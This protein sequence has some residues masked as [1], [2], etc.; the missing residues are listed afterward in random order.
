MANVELQV[1]NNL[2]K[3]V[4]KAQVADFVF[5]ETAP[6]SL[7]HQVVRW[8]RASWR[9]GTHKTKTRAEVTGGGRKPWKQKGSGRARQGSIRAVQW[10]GGGIA[11]GPNPRNYS[12]KQNRKERRIA[13]KSALSYKALDN[14]ITVIE[15]LDFATPKTKEMKTLLENLKLSDKKVLFVTNEL[16]ENFILAGRNLQNI[17]MMETPDVNVLDLVNADMVVITEAALKELEE[18]LG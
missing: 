17:M 12:K 7:L 8:Q 5:D 3:Q 4:S 11:F 18:V 14:E 13:L 6:K 15:T 1:I 2:G 10:R 9:A 16:T